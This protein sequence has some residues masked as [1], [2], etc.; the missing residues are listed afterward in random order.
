MQYEKT[1][2]PTKYPAADYQQLARLR[3]VTT[4][5]QLQGRDRKSVCIFYKSFVDFK[6]IYRI[7]L[8]ILDDIRLD[9]LDDEDENIYPTGLRDDEDEN[10]Y[11]TGLREQAPQLYEDYSSAIY[12][13]LEEDGVLNPQETLYKGLLEVYNSRR[14]GYA[15]LKGI[16][17]AT[18][19]VQSKDLG[20]LSTPPQPQPGSTP[21]NFASRLNNFFRGQQQC[22]RIY[23]DKEQAMMYLQGM[24]RESTYTAATQQLM[25]ELCDT[26]IFSLA[27]THA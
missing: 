13:R 4:P 16:L 17:A 5:N 1:S 27:G 23:K 12:A 22:G 15:L 9:R 10:I 2:I 19:M 21:H 14:D 25:Y 7:P 6:R 8:K 18:V 20:A 3:A 11:P 26:A 24:T